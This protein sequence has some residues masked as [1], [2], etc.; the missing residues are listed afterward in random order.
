M[1]LT[2]RA[3]LGYLFGL[4][5]ISLVAFLTVVWTVEPTQSTGLTIILFYL[6]LTGGLASFFA[7]IGVWLRRWGK[8]NEALPAQ[9]RVAFRQGLLLALVIVSALLLQ[10]ADLYSWWNMI[11]LVALATVI[12][13][14]FLAKR[15]ERRADLRE[16]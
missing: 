12:E 15:V 7:V 13:S 6:T 5:I 11:L 4:F 14:L 10:R 16:L 3:Y 8:K 1:L 9:V 2:L